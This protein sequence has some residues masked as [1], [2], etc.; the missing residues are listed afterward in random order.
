[1]P[2]FR[3]SLNT[4]TIRSFTQKI[5]GVLR[6]K[7]VTCFAPSLLSVSGLNSL[8]HSYCNCVEI[9][10]N[11]NSSK[12]LLIFLRCWCTIERVNLFRIFASSW[13]WDCQKSGRKI[14][15][16]S[17]KIVYFTKHF[18]YEH[19]KLRLPRTAHMSSKINH[20]WASHLY[21]LRCNVIKIR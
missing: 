2:C 14:I 6:Q 15:C 3:F 18:K 17:P 9:A 4:V 1:M 11:F 8:A 5:I 21:W 16:E 13:R 12:P 20:Y 10:F 19:M 7:W